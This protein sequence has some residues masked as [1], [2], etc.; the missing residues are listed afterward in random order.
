MPGIEVT[1]MSL[2]SVLTGMTFANAGVGASHALTY[3][4]GAACHGSHGLL[5][6]LLLPYVMEYNLSV[7]QERMAKIAGG[8]TPGVSPLNS[9]GKYCGML[10]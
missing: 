7:Q 10:T 6:G 8:T 2:A 4:A 1:D 5:A 3:P 9:W